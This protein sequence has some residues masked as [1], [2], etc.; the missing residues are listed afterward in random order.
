MLGGLGGKGGGSYGGFGAT[1]PQYAV[2]NP[3]GAG[4]QQ[5]LGSGAYTQVSQPQSDLW[6]GGNPELPG[7]PDQN[8]GL[9]TAYGGFG[10]SNLDYL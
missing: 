1:G 4:P 6:A 7:Q 8:Q 2:G 3:Y 9:A 5:Q 10:G